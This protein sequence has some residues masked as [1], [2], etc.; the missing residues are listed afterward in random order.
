MLL[1]SRAMP[2]VIV[3]LWPG[4]PKDQKQRLSDAIIRDVTSI[5]NYGEELLSV[6]FEEVSA[7][8]LKTNDR[9]AR[10]CSSVHSC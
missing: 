9:E 2:H 1:R 6:G 4:K 10:R 3:R 5:L 7:S 8:D